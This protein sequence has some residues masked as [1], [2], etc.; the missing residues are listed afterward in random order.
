MCAGAQALAAF[1]MTLF[2]VTIG[3][4]SGG[5]DLAAAPP[6][7]A[8]IAAQLTC[9]AA[10]VL[11]G[12]RALRIPTD[13]ACIA[14]NAAVGGPG[15]AAAMASGRGWRHLLPTAVLLGSVGYAVGTGLGLAVLRVLW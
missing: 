6:L 2:F 10:V 9:H 11:V 12:A 5:A 1:L 8:L 4:A 14:S 7:L 15:T 3:V 13:V